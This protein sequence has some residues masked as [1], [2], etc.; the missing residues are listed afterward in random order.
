MIVTNSVA[1]TVQPSLAAAHSNLTNVEERYVPIPCHS[2]Q[3][4]GVHGVTLAY[5]TTSKKKRNTYGLVMKRVQ[6]LKR[7]IVLLR[8]AFELETFVS[9]SRD[10]ICKFSDSFPYHSYISGI[11]RALKEENLTIRV[12]SSS[13]HCRSQATKNAIASTL[14]HSVQIVRL[15]LADGIKRKHIQLIYHYSWFYLRRMKEKMP[16]MW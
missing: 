10:K 7:A 15:K 13:H 9:R 1:G 4:I 3:D 14:S 11:A 8:I 5:G 16:S 2:I 12:E 6:M